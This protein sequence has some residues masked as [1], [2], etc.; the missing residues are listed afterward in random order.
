VL[1]QPE[2]ERVVLPGPKVTPTGP[3]K[4]LDGNCNW[5][6]KDIPF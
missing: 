1:V 2:M 3:S 6:Q 5:F 4:Q